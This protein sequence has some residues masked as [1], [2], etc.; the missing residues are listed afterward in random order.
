MFRG[1]QAV[2]YFVPDV[3]AAAEWYGQLLDQPVK[4][5]FESEGKIRGALIQVE[6]VELFLHLADDKMQPSRAGQ[7]AYWR[8]DEMKRCN[9]ASTAIWCKTI[10]RS[11]RIENNQTICQMWDQFGNLFGMQGNT[12]QL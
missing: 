10:S 3:K 1:I 4:H 11:I 8:V 2:F 7:V 6:E 5:Y 12:T 9:R